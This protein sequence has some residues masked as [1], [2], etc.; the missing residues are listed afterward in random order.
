MV[1]MEQ[2]LPE[3]VENVILIVKLVLDLQIQIVSNVLMEDSYIKVD[4]YPH[5]PLEPF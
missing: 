1:T 2:L 3:P 5:V 4:A